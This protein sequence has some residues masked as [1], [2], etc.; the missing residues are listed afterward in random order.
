MDISSTAAVL[1]QLDDIPDGGA[2][3]V[4]AVVN[5]ED[6]SLVVWRRDGQARAYLNICPHAGRRLDWAPGKFLVKNDVLVCAAHG[7]SFAAATG[8][9]TAGPCRGD[10]LR[11]VPV[12][13]SEGRVVLSGT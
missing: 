3:E 11:A 13:V 1:C 12:D 5:G 10:R 2:I 8:E 6:E 7:A 9:C 4:Q